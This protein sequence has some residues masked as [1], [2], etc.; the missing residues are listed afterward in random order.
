MARYGACHTLIFLELIPQNH[1][2][3]HERFK[4]FKNCQS[5]AMKKKSMFKA[6]S[7]PCMPSA[8]S[9]GWFVSLLIC[10]EVLLAGLCERK[11]LFRLKIYDRLR[12]ATAKRTG[13]ISRLQAACV[14]APTRAGWRS[15]QEPPFRSSE[16]ILC[17]HLSALASSINRPLA[18]RPSS[19]GTS[20][21]H[22][23]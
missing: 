3:C 12:Q 18:H 17:T 19:I 22:H 23:K 15:D 20:A 7:V 1:T 16:H 11:I 14:E 10:E 5:A 8:C 6:K 21:P 2:S 13:C 9:V 4:E